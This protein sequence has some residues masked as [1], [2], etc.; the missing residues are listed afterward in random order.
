[1]KIDWL[2]FSFPYNEKSRVGLPPH[3]SFNFDERK[4][5]RPLPRYERAYRLHNGGL[6]CIPSARN[7]REKR[8]IQWTG[9]DCDKYREIG[10][11][12]DAMIEQ[13]FRAKGSATR[14]DCAFDADNPAARVQDIEDSW[15]NGK[16]KTKI[17]T[18]TK[19]A[20]KGRKGEPENTLYFGATD[21]DQ[22]IVVYDK[23]KQLKTLWRVWVRV[24]GRFY[25]DAARRL[26]TEAL[27]HQSIDTVARAKMRNI[28]RT[29]VEWFEAMMQGDDVEMDAL[30]YKNDTWKWLNTQVAPSIDRFSELHPSEQAKMVRWLFGRLNVVMPDWEQFK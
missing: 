26:S 19:M 22:K 16:M 15:D 3:E 1:M 18:L 7:A 2:T 27:K 11:S 13:V 17:R 20:R 4:P 12:D 24:E 10:M 8:L 14:V 29:G 25:G 6:Y 30:E 9:K 21:S 23:A 5:A 28:M